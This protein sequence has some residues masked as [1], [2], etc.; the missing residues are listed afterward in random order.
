[1]R[2]KLLN[3]K[4]REAIASVLPIT[5]IVLMLCF[6]ITPIPNSML[7]SFA[8]GAVMLVVG[9]AFFTLGADTAMT[10]IGNKVGACITRSRA[11]KTRSLSGLWPLVWE[12]F[13]LWKQ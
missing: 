10:P 6:T 1:M 5:F 9:M 3:D 12:S 13:W 11:L 2:S 7:V 8:F 4:L